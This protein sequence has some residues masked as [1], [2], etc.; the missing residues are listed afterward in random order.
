MFQIYDLR[1]TG[2]LLKSE[3]MNQRINNKMSGICPIHTCSNAF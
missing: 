1:F 2:M 3:M